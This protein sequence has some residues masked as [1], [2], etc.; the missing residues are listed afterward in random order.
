[1]ELQAHGNVIFIIT[2]YISVVT[3]PLTVIAV[4]EI[5][6]NLSNAVVT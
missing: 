2:N 3:V 5:F 4:Q 1:M 6:T